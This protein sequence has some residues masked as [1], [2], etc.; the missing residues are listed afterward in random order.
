MKPKLDLDLISDA[1]LLLQKY[2]NHCR[3]FLALCLNVFLAQVVY[4]AADNNS[5]TKGNAYAIGLLGLVVVA[6]SI[7]LLVVMFQPQRF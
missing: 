3:L 1:R 2:P 6:L 7:Y 5:L 4:A